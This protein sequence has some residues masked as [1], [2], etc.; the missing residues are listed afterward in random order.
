MTPETEPLAIVR[1]KLDQAVDILKEKDLDLWLTFVRETTQV[2]DPCV[3][4]ILGFH[5]TWQSALMVTNTGQRIAIVGRFDAENVSNI[6]AYT[7]VIGYDESIRDP[8]LEQVRQINPRRIAINFSTSDPAADG[9]THGLFRVLANILGGTEYATRLIS[10]DEVIAA[11][12]GRK[13]P[14]EVNRI[15]AAVAASEEILR[16]VRAWVKVGMREEEIAEFIHRTAAE[17]GL[18]SAWEPEY[19]PIVCAGPDGVFGHRMPGRLKTRRGCL[20]QMDYGA[21]KDGFVGDLQRTMY[22]RRRREEQLPEE[23]Q[24]AWDAARGAL[25]AG[26]SALRPGA[27]GWEVDAM[28]RKTLVDAGYP[29]YRHAFGHHIG[30]NAH[31]GATILGPRWERYGTAIEGTV[32]AGNVFAIELGTMVPGFGYIGCE[33]N[34]LVTPDGAEYLSEPQEQIWTIDR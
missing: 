34:V 13:S 31:D 19:C 32:E 26:R 3:D 9:L 23:V 16:D 10:A 29:E 7:S 25:E 1:E 8:L 24:K 15:R 4:L 17:R 22:F 5:L 6:G 11:L 18:G 33:E 21:R 2:K 20:L 14:S 12:R 28:A 27:K 30:R